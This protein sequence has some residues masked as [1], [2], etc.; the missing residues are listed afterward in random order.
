MMKFSYMKK[1]LSD[2][3]ETCDDL[4]L[5]SVSGDWGCSYRIWYRSFSVRKM[6]AVVDWRNPPL[7]HG[8]AEEELWEVVASDDKNLLQRDC[9]RWRG[10]YFFFIFL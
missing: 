7:R 5:A 9:R 3:K 1:A 2:I 10:F 8:S 4:F 6:S